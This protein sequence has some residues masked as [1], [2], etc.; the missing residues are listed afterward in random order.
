VDG[1]ASQCTPEDGG[2]EEEVVVTV[3][4]WRGVAMHKVTYFKS[5]SNR[6]RGKEVVVRDCSHD[7][8]GLQWW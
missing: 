4:G 2:V 8:E 1:E 7:G 3:C 6:A 5:R